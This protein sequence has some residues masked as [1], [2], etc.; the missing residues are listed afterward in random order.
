MQYRLPCSTTVFHWGRGNGKGGG[1][2]RSEELFF[3]GGVPIYTYIV[4]AFDF[5]GLRGE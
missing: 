4:T 3:E 1:K 5:E 2:S